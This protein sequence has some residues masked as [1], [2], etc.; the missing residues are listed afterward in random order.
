MSIHESLYSRYY[1]GQEERNYHCDEL[2]L[3]SRASFHW[4]HS[5]FSVINF[6]ISSCFKLQK[7][8]QDTDENL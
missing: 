5:S 3:I 7:L 2:K 4:E 6:A 8:L 1:H